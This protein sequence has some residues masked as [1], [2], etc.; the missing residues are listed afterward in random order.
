LK[1]QTK[2]TQ[3]WKLTNE[4]K[5]VKDLTLQKATTHYGGR[6]WTAWF[7]K[8]IPFQEGPYKFHGLPG[9]IVELY[10]DKNDYKFDLVK[11]VKLD[12]PVNNM[13]IK[14]SKEMSVP[15][16]WEKYKSTKLAYYESLSIFS[17]MGEKE[18]SS[19]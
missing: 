6:D 2:D 9:L 10:Y 13:F 17:E 19:F 11:S 7:T 1:L 4:S 5:K 3:N 18:I 16:T 8:E 15:T 14:M 12:K